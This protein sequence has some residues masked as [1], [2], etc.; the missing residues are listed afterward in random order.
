MSYIEKQRIISRQYYYDNTEKVIKRAAKYN[1]IIY[2]KVNLTLGKV[3]FFV[4]TVKRNLFRFAVV[5]SE[6]SEAKL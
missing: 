2:K 6:R 5:I 4:F 3:N 1:N